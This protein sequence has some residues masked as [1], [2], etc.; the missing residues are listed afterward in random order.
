MMTTDEYIA[1][2]MLERTTPILGVTT[3]ELTMPA[4]K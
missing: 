3:S 4:T 2:P 1:A